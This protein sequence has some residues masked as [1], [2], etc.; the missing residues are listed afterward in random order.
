MGGAILTHNETTRK[1][2]L[3]VAPTTLATVFCRDR[4]L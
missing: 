3:E 1:L 4:E 2:S